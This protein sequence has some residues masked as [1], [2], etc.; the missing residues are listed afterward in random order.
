MEK[1]RGVDLVDEV[2]KY[3]DMNANV[4]ALLAKS[5]WFWSQEVN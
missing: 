4:D 1:E 2:A 3:S 5:R